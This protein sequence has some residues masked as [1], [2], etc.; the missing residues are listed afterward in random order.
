MKPEKR[1]DWADGGED[2]G[3]ILYMFYYVFTAYWSPLL[4]LSVAIHDMF[5]L[6]DILVMLGGKI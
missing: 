4:G 6:A 1:R 5:E 3:R 2:S